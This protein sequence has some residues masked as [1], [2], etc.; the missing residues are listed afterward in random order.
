MALISHALVLPDA[1]FMA[2]Y[3]AAEPY[4][5]AFERVAVVRSPAGNDL[6]RF[7]DVSAVQAP[8]V[9]VRDDA[10]AHIRRIYPMVV[11][12][13]VI[14]ASTPAQMQAMLQERIN[15]RDRYGAYL[16]DG[17]LNDRFT[18]EGWPSDARPARVLRPFD[19]PL[20]GGRKHE[21]WDI[22]APQGTTIRAAAP[23]IV[24]TV[25]RQPT[26]LGYGQYV[27]VS[28]V[29]GGQTYLVTY[30]LL[31][32]LTVS[33]GQRVNIGDPLGQSDGA[34]VKIVVQQ[35][36]AGIKGYLLP[37]VID[38]APLIYWQTMRLK[39]TADGLR[40]R[41]RPGTAYRA[42][43]LLKPSDRAEPLE[44]HGR[45]LLR[46]GVSG[47][48]IKLRSPQSVEGFCAAEYLVAEDT[49]AARTLNMT[50]MNLDMLHPLGRPDAA[51]LKGVGWV[52]FAYNVSMGRGLTDL[53]TAY[54]LYAPHI[55]RYRQAG[56]KVILV[57][58]H[59]TYGE[60]AGY[61]WPY[62]TTPQWRELTARYADFARRI[63]GQYA[64]RGLVYQIWNEQD[65]AG[66]NE[67]S[68]PMPAAD[69]GHLLGEATR[70]IRAADPLAVVITGGH[71]SGPGRGA[72]YASAA[73]AAAGVLPDGV[74]CHSYGRG[75]AGSKYSPFGPVDDDVD[76]YGKVIPGAPIWITEWGVLDYPDDPAGGVADYAAGFVERLKRLY[77]GKVAAAVWYA[78][79]DGMH[80]GYGLVDRQDRPKQPLYDRFL[81]L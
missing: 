37:D 26:A 9:W 8:G 17:H 31:R 72:P 11:R 30:A 16:N 4:T 25:V 28:S 71:V 79:A 33:M 5:Q 1:D 42:L 69:Y 15:R 18:L 19:A 13:D 59:Q 44:P 49:G 54:D 66:V 70:A 7:R 53:N 58:S 34:Q 63:A 80:N 74:A 20:S 50:G 40:I 56:L 75:P 60:G 81:K 76:A 57:L 51:R 46:L 41:E 6:N 55:E 10:L 29:V 77:A 43:G 68:V 2:W 35:P 45:T 38:P 22:H 52:R 36:G 47:Q 67:A 73:L 21:G 78:W 61:V 27:Q 3:R 48:W 64:G 23:G 32:S 12:V 62:M 14:R 65:T 39:T 24:A